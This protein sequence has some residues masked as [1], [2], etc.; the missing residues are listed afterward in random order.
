MLRVYVNLQ[1]L[2]MQVRLDN[3]QCFISA[4]MRIE[5]N[6]LVLLNFFVFELSK[7]FSCFKWRLQNTSKYRFLGVESVIKKSSRNCCGETQ[8][9]LCKHDT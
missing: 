6:G 7:F 1:L 2:V 5:P 4:F 8:R 9:R 3:I